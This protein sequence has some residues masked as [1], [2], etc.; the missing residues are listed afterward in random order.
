[1]DP[2]SITS[3]QGHSTSQRPTRTIT[4][5]QTVVITVGSHNVSLVDVPTAEQE[6]P[7]AK[8]SK[9]AIKSTF[10]TSVSVHLACRGLPWYLKKQLCNSPSRRPIYTQ[11]PVMVRCGRYQLPHLGRRESHAEVGGASLPSTGQAF[12]SQG[13]V[14]IICISLS[15]A[16]VGCPGKF[17]TS[18]V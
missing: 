16:E 4:V 10:L 6:T 11:V 13:S 1:M 3:L 12:S 7:G 8:G 2:R 18:T 15:H 5:V 9:G 17:T 14:T